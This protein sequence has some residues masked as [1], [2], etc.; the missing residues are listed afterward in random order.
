MIRRAQ[1]DLGRGQER[2]RDKGSPKLVDALNV[3]AAH[4]EQPLTTF[5]LAARVA[6][7]ERT[8]NRLFQ[9]ELGMTAG[10]YY[11]FFR[12]QTARHLAGE[13]SLSQDQIAMRCGFSSG[14]ALA[15]SFQSS[16]G[17]PLSRCRS[18]SPPASAPP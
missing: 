18:L 2:L 4:I 1:K 15:R 10:K 11:R 8:L 16:F 12:L 14:A 7:S 3:M 13:T 9:R 5:Q 6:V 17:I